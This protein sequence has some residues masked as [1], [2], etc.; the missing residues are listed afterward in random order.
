MAPVAYGPISRSTLSAVTSCSYSVRAR[1]GLDWSSLTHPLDRPAEQAAALVELLDV[2]LADDLVH[3]RGGRQ[4]PG[5]RERAA[6]AD[7]RAGLR[8]RQPAAPARRPRRRRGGRRRDG[9]WSV[10]WLSPCDLSRRGRHAVSPPERR[11]AS[12]ARPTCRA[13][14]DRIQLSKLA[15]TPRRCSRVS[16]TMRPFAVEQR[17][18][19]A[20]VDL[21]ERHGGDVHRRQR[22]LQA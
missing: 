14:S 16:G 8:L 21:R 2:D 7:R 10:S 9:S 4:R 19:A 5:Q 3:L 15:S 12:P 13:R 11:S 22:L 6:D 17:G 20:Q 1:S 18:D